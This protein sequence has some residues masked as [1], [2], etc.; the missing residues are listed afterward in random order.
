MMKRLRQL[1]MASLL[2]VAF[3]VLTGS[4]FVISE[5]EQAVILQFGRPVRVIVGDRTP[6][7]MEQI[8]SWME[9]NAPDVA[10]SRGPG[11]YFKIPLL[12]QVRVFDDR[13]ME[14]DDEPADV[15]T[16]DKKHIQVDCYARWRIIN[17][18]LFLRSIQTEGAARS[19]IDDI[20]Y[21]VLRQELGR[22]NLIH[23]VRS[24]NNPIGLGDYVRLVNSISYSDTLGDLVMEEGELSEDV[25]LVRVPEGEG[26]SAIMDRVAR[27]CRQ[28]L[29][30]YGIY[31]VDVRIKRADLPA[32]NQQAVFARMQAER[33][34][35]STRYRAE[36]RRMA[37]NI[38]A[39]TDL[40][41]DSIL[42][43]A[44]R[45]ALTIRGAAD[46][47]AAAIFAGAYSSF[48]DFYRFQRSL[49]TMSEV[50][51]PD[52]R[53]VTSTSGGIFQYLVGR[54]GELK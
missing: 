50:M 41:V 14:Y 13:I 49:E 43:G 47:A 26:R 17:P 19:R 5:T 34:R 4:L 45:T 52:D 35:I 9:A 39:G 29:L 15:V 37:A 11:L 21:S 16:M 44:T 36:G 54:P 23:I 10:I 3:L 46:S 33:N 30:E 28:M 1:V 7:Q 22:S 38:V 32:E 24:T 51:G 27:T 25:S 42:A 40:E 6:E 18:L 53:I 12:Q 20:V 8:E 48:P 2:L 31:L